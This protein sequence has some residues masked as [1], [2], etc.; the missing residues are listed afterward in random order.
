MFSAVS[1][2]KMPPCPQVPEV[3]L[4][5]ETP[6]KLETEIRD[7]TASF[8]L[9][10][11]LI[12]PPVMFI[13]DSM[14]QCDDDKFSILKRPADASRTVTQAPTACGVFAVHK[15][16]VALTW[17][18]MKESM[19]IDVSKPVTARNRLPAETQKAPV[20]SELERKNIKSDRMERFEVRNT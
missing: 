20:Q 19:D 7:I 14:V 6:L 1:N 3:E 13:A 12:H 16:P 4:L 10:R 5:E 2:A 9:L 18:S 17:H 15:T 8:T 11:K